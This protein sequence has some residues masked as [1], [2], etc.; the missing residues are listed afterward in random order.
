MGLSHWTIELWVSA[1]RPPWA[2]G[3]PFNGDEW[4]VSTSDLRRRVAKVWVW[5]ASDTEN[6]ET[7]DPLQTLFHE[8]LHVSLTDGGVTNTPEWLEF[9]IDR[10]ADAI[11]RLSRSPH[12]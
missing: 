1:D 10:L 9:T 3:P 11:A 4:G 5:P 8:L 12:D 6:G 2:V 7:N